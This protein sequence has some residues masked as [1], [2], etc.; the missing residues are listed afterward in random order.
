MNIQSTENRAE[1]ARRIATQFA[2]NLDAD[3]VDLVQADKEN[4]T[5]SDGC[6]ASHNQCDA[7]MYMAPA[8][9]S[10]MGRE[11]DLQSDA[12]TILWGEAWD[13]AKTTGFV[14]LATIG[15]AA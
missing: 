8:F 6:C 14:K 11:I 3:G 4:R 13:Y 12:D 1:F 15:A 2:L 7:N 10:V 5:I 9:A